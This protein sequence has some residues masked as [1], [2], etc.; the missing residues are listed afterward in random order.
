MKYAR[1]TKEQKAQYQDE[2]R[3]LG[4][5]LNVA[6]QSSVGAPGDRR[7]HLRFEDKRT[8]N[9]FRVRHMGDAS[10]ANHLLLTPNLTLL[11]ADSTPDTLTAGGAAF[12]LA[13]ALGADA[14]DRTGA[15]IGMTN[16][17]LEGMPDFGQQWNAHPQDMKASNERLYNRVGATGKYVGDIAPPGKVA[18]AAKLAE[19]V[20]SHGA[21]A[22]AVI[23]PAARK[24]AYRYRGTEKRPDAHI[25]TQYARAIN[26]A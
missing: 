19:V 20:G 10:A 1:L 8:G 15:R 26:A 3:Q 4:A 24:T 18:A 17:A 21:E 23:G 14:G 12:G 25:V 5:F 2:Y 22:E 11:E 16:Q 7:T 6:A 13:Q 9:E